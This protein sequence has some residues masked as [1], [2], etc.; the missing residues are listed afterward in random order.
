MYPHTSN[1]LLPV[2]NNKYIQLV[3]NTL[4]YNTQDAIISSPVIP[5]LKMHSFQ[6]IPMVITNTTML[7]PVY[8]TRQYTLI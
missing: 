7:Q 2:G 3:Y 6:L 8:D 5:T 4:Q 1:V